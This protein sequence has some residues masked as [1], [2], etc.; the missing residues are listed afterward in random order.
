MISHNWTLEKVLLCIYVLSLPTDKT[1]NGAHT[2]CLHDH[3]MLIDEWA[4]LRSL[5]TSKSNCTRKQGGQAQPGSGREDQT[6]KN[7]SKE[8]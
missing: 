6:E 4:E 2:Q 3:P 5:N 8:S 1:K 7:K